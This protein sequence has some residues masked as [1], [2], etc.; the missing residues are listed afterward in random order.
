MK[1]FFITLLKGIGIALA[2]SLIVCFFSWYWG[3]WRAI[4]WFVV[5]ALICWQ[6]WKYLTEDT[7]IS[8]PMMVGGKIEEHKY[9][10]PLSCKIMEVGVVAFFTLLCAGCFWVIG[11]GAEWIL[12]KP[13]AIFEH[14]IFN[15]ILSILILSS[16]WWII[17][18]TYCAIKEFD[19]QFKLLLFLAI[20]KWILIVGISVVVGLL[21]LH[22][23][24]PPVQ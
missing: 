6:I 13:S 19:K 20:L 17:R 16:C 5:I 23:G 8:K 22:Y 24:L 12:N 18:I 15:G 21:V 11:W 9:C 2:V 7:W 4:I 14:T 10:E 3:N 1:D